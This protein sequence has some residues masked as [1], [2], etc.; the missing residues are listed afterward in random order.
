MIPQE[1][2]SV[3]AVN[4]E[5]QEKAGGKCEFYNS[6]VGMRLRQISF[7]SRST[8]PPLENSRHFFVGE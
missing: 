5:A 1:D 4:L 3:E 7:I 6:L 2:D 8:V